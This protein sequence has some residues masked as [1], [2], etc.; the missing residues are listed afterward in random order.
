MNEELIDLLTAVLIYTEIKEKGKN[1]FVKSFKNAGEEDE[2]YQILVEC[3]NRCE[4]Y[5]PEIDKLNRER[6]KAIEDNE[7]D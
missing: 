3:L 1:P 4:V 2:A 7:T 6:M 5:F